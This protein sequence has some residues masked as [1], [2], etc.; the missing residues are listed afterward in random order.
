MPRAKL[1]S[2]PFSSSSQNTE[3]LRPILSA[4]ETQDVSVCRH[5]PGWGQ[6]GKRKEPYD[7]M[8]AWVQ[9]GLRPS[10]CEK[11]C[12]LANNIHFAFFSNRAPEF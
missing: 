4:A 9:L 11:D 6:R 2:S 10:N 5:E 7:L 3:I 1:L 8:S 12:W